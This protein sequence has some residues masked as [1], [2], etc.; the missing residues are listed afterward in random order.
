MS[1]VESISECLMVSRLFACLVSPIYTDILH[2]DKTRYNDNLNGTK[3]KFV[4]NR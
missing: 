2:N 1:G 4:M 3:Y